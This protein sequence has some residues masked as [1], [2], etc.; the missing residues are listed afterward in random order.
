MYRVV[1]VEDDPMVSLINHTYVERDT[2]F[3]VV[4]SFQNGR[5]ALEWLEQNPVD[6]VVLDVYMPLFTGEELLR[7]LRRRQIEDVYKRQGWCPPRWRSCRSAG[8]R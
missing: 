3:Q 2:R 5:M 8:R 6:L 7:A 1:I 4:Q